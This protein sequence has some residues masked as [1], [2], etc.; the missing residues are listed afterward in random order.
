M[1]KT[2]YKA[3]YLEKKPMKK[4]WSQSQQM[5]AEARLNSEEEQGE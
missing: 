1:R 3:F 4:S 2:C 5:E